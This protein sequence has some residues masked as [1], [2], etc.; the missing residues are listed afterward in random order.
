[1]VSPRE[2][3]ESRAEPPPEEDDDSF[4]MVEE[5][6]EEKEGV[7]NNYFQYEEEKQVKKPELSSTDIV[8]IASFRLPVTLIKGADGK[9]TTKASNAMLYPTLHKLKDFG[10]KNG[11]MINIKWIGWAGVFPETEDEKNLVIEALAAVNCIPIFFPKEL[12]K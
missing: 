6:E 8:T 12:I 5:G 3:L 2:R 1:M 10:A 11:K 9:Y 7:D 4:T